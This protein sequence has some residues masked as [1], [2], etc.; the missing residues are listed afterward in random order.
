M[1]K[2]PGVL[3]LLALGGLPPQPPADGVIAGRVV[4]AGT[5]KPVGGAMVRITGPSIRRSGPWGP[6]LH[7][8]AP[9]VLTAADGRFE[10]RHLPDGTFGVT[11][12]K[13]GYA[14]GAYGR[15]RPGG[16]VRTVALAAQQP[17]RDVAVSIWKNGAISG[18]LTDESG[19]AVVGAQVRLWRATFV[20]GA[21][22][23]ASSG[24]PAY[25][26]D[27][28]AYRFG[29]LLSG[30]YIVGTSAPQVSTL[31]GPAGEVRVGRGGAFVTPASPLSLQV[32]D[33][34]I[35]IGRPAI[36]PPPPANGHV[37]VYPPTFSPSALA[38]VHAAIVT[39]AS[40]EER[41][42]VDIQVQ[43]VTIARVAGMLMDL[44]GP[45]SG[46]AI[47]LHAKGF[48]GASS[49]ADDIAAIS[50]AQGRFVFPAV[51]HGDYTLSAI[52]RI[53]QLYRIDLPLTVSGDIDNLTAVMRNGL[54][55]TGR[56]EYQGTT[57]PPPPQ[58]NLT[59]R[60]VPFTLDAADGSGPSPIGS[61]RWG[62]SGFTIEGFAAGRY[63]VR[64]AQS[65]EGW[66]FKAALLNGAD[67]STAPF[68]LTRDVDD[69][70]ITFTDRWSGLG[71]TVHD[72][73]GNADA[74]ATVL[75][76][77]TTA[78]GWRDYGS[79][80][81]RLK[82]SATTDRGEFAIS[83]LPP[84]DYYAVAIPED[85]SDD[86]RDPRTLD[87]LARIATSITIAEGEHRMIDLR[88]REVPR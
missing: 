17:L 72:A 71:G 41:S 75:V 83:S 13:P 1:L 35:S 78:E 49:A 18:T 25:T 61:A 77:P 46:G 74:A 9:D 27:R 65:P 12:T 15:R 67:V 5:G 45:V 37:M 4:D 70:V 53:S 6:G 34:S 62:A 21:R 84:G 23:F 22:R 14:E 10:F 80:P 7:G 47:Q 3:L 73:N 30:D 88:T 16:A 51:P 52:E 40:G 26:D 38:P 33:A 60:P 39:L 85:Q 76:F 2:V 36:V 43:P 31:G 55:V 58:G 64:V 29:E 87:A 50:D 24:Q 11:A 54:S 19:E 68:D 86:W 59:F 66:M 48:E 20:A 81:R 56:L 44:N 28:G 69:L 8:G 79:S 82:S 42:G 32:G 63:V 57:A